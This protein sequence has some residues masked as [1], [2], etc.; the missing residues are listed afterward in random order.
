MGRR[1]KPISTPNRALE[2]LARWLRAQRAAGGW[3]Y[4]ELADRAGCHATTLQRAASGHE[5]PSARAVQAYARACGAPVEAAMDLWRQARGDDPYG[6]GGA[7]GAEPDVRR[8]D[9]QVQ[10][11]P[12]GA[13]HAGRPPHR[14]RHGTTGGQVGEAAAQHRPPHSAG[15][16]RAV[17]S[18]ATDRVPGRLRG[19]RS[20]A[21]P[22]G[23]RVA[24]GPGACGT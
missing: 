11:R 14:A 16:D 9:R 24:P 18:A 4:A 10:G 6:P 22:V 19:R 12:P 2:K 5:V 15:T 1:E 7:V 3:S 21:S 13:L 17:R 8:R 23:R 20:R